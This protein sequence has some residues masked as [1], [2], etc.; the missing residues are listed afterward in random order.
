MAT[1][2]HHVFQNFI[3]RIESIT[4][5]ST[6]CGKNFYRLDTKQIAID[7]SSGLER[8]FIISWL[9]SGDDDIPTDQDIR[10]SEHKF[11]VQVVYWPGRGW[12]TAHEL[13]LQDR[14]DLIKCLRDDAKFCG[15]DAEHSTDA[16]RLF[17]RVRDSD[18]IDMSDPDVWVLRMIWKCY[19][20]DEE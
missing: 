8:S 3:Y 9:G 2:L 17:G 11:L 16:L 15:Y 4:P 18:E 20:A 6:I 10:V 13:I 1:K 19:I 14:H 7:E 5:T 12:E